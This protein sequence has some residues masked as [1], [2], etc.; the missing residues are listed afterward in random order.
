MP[1]IDALDHPEVAFHRAFE[2]RSCGLVSGAIVGGERLF[3][4]LEL[5]HDGAPGNAGVEGLDLAAARQ[6]RAAAGD[7]AALP[8]WRIPPARRDP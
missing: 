3:E 8:T 6:E 1:S 2:F 5:D 7:D 4:A